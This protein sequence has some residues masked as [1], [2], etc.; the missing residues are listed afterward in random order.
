MGKIAIFK[1]F[2]KSK[3]DC[4]T[5]NGKFVVIIYLFPY[6]HKIKTLEYSS[7][8]TNSQVRD[9]IN[10]LKI[11]KYTMWFDY[12]DTINDLKLFRI[13]KSNI[14]TSSQIRRLN[15]T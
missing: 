1:K 5:N 6:I 15:Y 9:I 10:I 11:N 14:T 3:K 13:Y 8:S 7:N 2:N 12:I 4:L